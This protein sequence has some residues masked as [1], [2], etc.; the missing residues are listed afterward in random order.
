MRLF[1][2]TSVDGRDRIAAHGFGS[3][4]TETTHTLLGHAPDADTVRTIVVGTE[5]FVV[6]DLPDDVAA[7]Y[8]WVGAPDTDLYSVPADVLNAHRPFE[9]V[10]ITSWRATRDAATRDEP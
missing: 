4:R 1:H 6:V 10:A 7:R 5:W 9:F 8:L 2:L 3:G